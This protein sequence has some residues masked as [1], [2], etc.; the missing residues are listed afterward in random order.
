MFSWSS[1]KQQVVSLSTT[2]AEY[3]A[4]TNCATHAVWLQRLL[5]ELQFQDSPMKVFCDDKSIIYLTKNPIF[6]GCCK[7]IDIKHHYIQDLIKEK[8]IMLEYCTSEDHIT[9]IFTKP[10]KINLFLKM[11]NMMGTIK[12]SL[13]EN[14]R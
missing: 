2:E 5:S 12:L 14:V 9:D 6:N 10:L 13:R 7:K 11:K 8:E 1:K 3:I 4:T